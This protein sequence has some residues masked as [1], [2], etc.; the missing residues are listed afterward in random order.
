MGIR[1]SLSGKIQ[2]PLNSWNVPLLLVGKN[3]KNLDAQKYRKVVNFRKLNEIT[4][5][6]SYSFN[7]S[8][9]IPSITEILHKPKNC[10]ILFIFQLKKK[11]DKIIF[12]FK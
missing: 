7:A 2:L 10:T 8:L 4:I 1:Y 11:K 12:R 9:S 6:E 3:V 5:N